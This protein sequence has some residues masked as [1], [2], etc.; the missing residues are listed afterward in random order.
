MPERLRGA[1]R[2]TGAFDGVVQLRV[3]YE[4]SHSEH[5]GVVLYTDD[6]TFVHLYAVGDNPFENAT[7]KARVGERVHVTGIWRNGVLRVDPADIVV[8][9]ALPAEA[10]P[11]EALPAEAMPEEPQ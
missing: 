8:E 5:A 10:L 6:D 2:T 3:L 7:F 4:G 11:A 1:P 9:E